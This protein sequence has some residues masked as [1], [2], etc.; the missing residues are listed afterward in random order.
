MFIRVRLGLEYL[1][2]IIL[3][4]GKLRATWHVYICYCFHKYRDINFFFYRALHL[5][6]TIRTVIC[7]WRHETP[8][9]HAIEVLHLA[10]QY[11]FRTTAR[12]YSFC[13]T[14]L[15]RT[16]YK[17][18]F[19]RPARSSFNTP[20]ERLAFPYAPYVMHEPKSWSRLQLWCEL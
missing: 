11:E 1:S 19:G 5:F 17:L 2:E 3:A 18:M 13:F 9:V 10:F 12:S 4:R 7:S 15:Q 8:A 16:R 6:C 14:Y 20:Q